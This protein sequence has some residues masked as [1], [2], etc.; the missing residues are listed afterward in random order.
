MLFILAVQVE[1]VRDVRERQPGVRGGRHVREAVLPRGQQERR[2]W[3]LLHL[4]LH[5]SLSLPP[6]RPSP[7]TVFPPLCIFISLAVLL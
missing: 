4:N 2:E 3:L 6:P 5:P 1:V 7:V